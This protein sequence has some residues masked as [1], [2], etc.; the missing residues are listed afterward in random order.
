MHN[1]LNEKCA[2]FGI[3][4]N[5]SS[6]TEIAR[7]TYF[8]LFAL[9]HRGQEHSG[10]ATTDGKKIHLYKDG[11]LV[12][13]IYTEELLAK[14]PGFAAIG[15]NRYS[16]SSGLEVEYA[17]PF[18]YDNLFA[19]G[20]NGNLP[21]TKVLI[22]FLKSNNEITENYSDS[23]LMTET[24]G[25][26]MKKGDSLPDAVEKAYPL[27]TGAFSCVAL[28]L[29]TMVAFRDPCGIR[30][31]VLGKKENQII[32]SSETCALETI[33][34]KFIREIKPGEMIIVTKNGKK[35]KVQSRQL[36][37]AKPR[38]DIFEF[39]YFARYD[40]VLAGKS[41]YEVR[42][43]LGKMLARQNK[44]ENKVNVD[45]IIPIP[46]TAIS[47]AIGYAEESDIPF[48]M[49]ISKNRYINRTF[50]EPT[51]DVREEKVKLKLTP[52]SNVIRGKKIAVMDDS[53]VRGTTSK[54]IVKM[55]F[56]AGAKEVHFLVSSAPIRFPDF[57]G[58]DTPNQTELIASKKTIKEICK[59]LGATSLSYLSIDSMVAATG[60][61]KK[62]LSLSSFDGVYPI[63]IHERKKEINYDVPK[64]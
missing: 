23:R 43:N 52:L 42:K 29:D 50:I 24:I 64:D 22:D 59:F 45:M 53:I 28:G 30:P 25:V 51:Q 13:Q 39:V 11:G 60:L 31:L 16:T 55:L 10:I 2:V 20:H 33:G 36:A 35:N 27:F 8:G 18:L 21:S 37:K 44:K 15:H 47:A 46:E 19:L 58:I 5:K 40:S 9:Q 4:G 14:L 26:Y 56:D 7:K 1:D 3:F 38:L 12:S 57:Y 49:G 48:E 6:K 41:V 61:P 54:Q 63:D 62:H 17:Q 34:A 32:V